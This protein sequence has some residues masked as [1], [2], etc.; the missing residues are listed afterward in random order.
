MGTRI[1]Y[2]SHVHMDYFWEY[3]IKRKATN[4]DQMPSQERIFRMVPV[5]KVLR[6]IYDSSRDAIYCKLENITDN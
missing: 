2:S 5:N 1:Y 6:M 4:S 3:V